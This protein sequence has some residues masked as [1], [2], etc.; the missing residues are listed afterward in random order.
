[1]EF[2]MLIV[3]L[4]LCASVIM[5][6]YLTR[7]T[8]S[9]GIS[10]PEEAFQEEEITG[11]RKRYIKW[12]GLT[13]ILLILGMMLLVKDVTDADTG[14][15]IALSM[16]PLLFFIVAFWV[17]LK[18]HHKMKALKES[19]AW[20]AQQRQ[21]ATAHLTS[22]AERKAVY[23]NAWFVIPALVAMLSFVL[24]FLNYNQMPNPLPMKYDF[25]GNV[26]VWEEKT[27]KIVYLLPI[28]QVYMIAL[29]V[30]INS[31]IDR[32][33]QQIDPAHRKRSL[34]QQ[35][36]FRAYWSLFLLI[37]CVLIVGLFFFLQLTYLI[38]VPSTLITIVPIGI[39]TV[40]IIGAIVLSLITGQG[41]SRL[42]VPDSDQ[43]IGVQR[44]DDRYWK[45]GLFY[46]NRHDPALFLEKR[47]GVGWTVNLGRPT[48]WIVLAIILG[49]SLAL[50]L[51]T[52]W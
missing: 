30:F 24:T 47:M 11:V 14:R 41:G 43:G 20:H 36:S 16:L 31:M 28:I 29:F 5:M 13:S 22:A 10:I 44:D 42:R 1:M 6:P 37:T 48:V 18:A 26:T 45:L 38:E 23:S 7:K 9:F 51:W 25:A 19:K 50:S 27:Y 4:P 12:T 52:M 17:Y 3:L 34:K 8:I 32:A 40:I 2:F 46:I 15:I 39:S 49:S 33:K 35:Q 21:Y